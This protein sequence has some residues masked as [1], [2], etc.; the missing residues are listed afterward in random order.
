MPKKLEGY[1]VIWNNIRG[2]V[3]VSSSI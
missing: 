3:W 2:W 1:I